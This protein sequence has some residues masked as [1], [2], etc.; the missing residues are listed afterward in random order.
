MKKNR[1][2]RGKYESTHNQR[3]PIV[4]TQ[5]DRE[6]LAALLREAPATL[7]LGIAEFLREE[8]GRADIV[9]GAVAPTSVVRMG[10][11]VKYVDHTDGRIYRRGSWT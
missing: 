6:K 11:N 8:V 3:P 1:W 4:L 9:T 5:S 10:S 2:S 7:P